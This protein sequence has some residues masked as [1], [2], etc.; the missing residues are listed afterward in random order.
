MVALDGM[1]A[2]VGMVA[3]WLCMVG[4]VACWLCMVGMACWLC[5]V[6]L[7]ALVGMVSKCRGCLVGRGVGM[8]LVVGVHCENWL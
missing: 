5:I 7:V 4:M 6:G 8:S 2:L 3:C 1:V